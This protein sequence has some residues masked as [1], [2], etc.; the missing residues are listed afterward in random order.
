ML[1]SS[2][3][4]SFSSKQLQFTGKMGEFHSDPVYTEPVQNFPSFS[5][6]KPFISLRASCCGTAIAISFA[7]YRGHLDLSAQSPK[8]VSERV[9]GASRPR[10][11][12]K[13]ENN[14]KSTIFQVFFLVFN[15]VFDFFLTFSVPRSQEAR[16][17]FSRLFSDFGPKGPNDPCKW[18]TISQHCELLLDFFFS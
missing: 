12:K 11:P 9:P 1:F 16:E 18:S 3:F 4:S 17:P 5:Q 10:G 14:R 6:V 2:L 7:I 13:S 8:K 15:P